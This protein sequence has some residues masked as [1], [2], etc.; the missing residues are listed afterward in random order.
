[1]SLFL[2]MLRDGVLPNDMYA[3]N[4]DLDDAKLIFDR[5][6]HKDVVCYNSLLLGYSRNGLSQNLLSVFHEMSLA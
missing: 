5:I 1:M 6:K 2:D 3:K 4:R